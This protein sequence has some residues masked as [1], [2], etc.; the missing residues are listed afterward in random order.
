MAISYFTDDDL[1]YL[2]PI[3]QMVHQ[4]HIQQTAFANAAATNLDSETQANIVAPTTPVPEW[5]LRL[6]RTTNSRERKRLRTSGVDRKGVTDVAGGMIGKKDAI[7]KS[8]MIR[9]S[10]RRKESGKMGV[11]NGE[12]SRP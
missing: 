2:R 1:P 8:Q 12:K 7:R 10:K 5:M 11:H 6:S 4:V 9:S 3:A